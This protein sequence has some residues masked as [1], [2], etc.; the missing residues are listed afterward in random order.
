M[1]G[2]GWL[3]ARDEGVWRHGSPWLKPLSAA[4]PWISLAL[5]FLLFWLVR[6]TLVSAEGVLFDLPD[7]ALRDGEPTDMV[8]VML[9]VARET[10]VFFDDSRFMLG[11]A[12][13]EQAFTEQLA[14]RASRAAHKTLLV[15]ADR[16]VSG[17]DL[18]KFAAAA[19]RSGVRK[20]LFAEKRREAAE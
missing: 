4:A 10:A 6:D 16:R 2:R 8:A 7:V 14:E 5:V 19:R 20:V 15:L 9:P 3:P 17:G 1:N 12:L 11:D 13:S 18:M